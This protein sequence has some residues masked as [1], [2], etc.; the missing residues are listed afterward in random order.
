MYIYSRMDTEDGPDS[1]NNCQCTNMAQ[2]PLSLYPEVTFLLLL[3]VCWGGWF[4]KTVF[5]MLTMYLRCCSEYSTVPVWLLMSWLQSSGSQIFSHHGILCFRLGL[6]DHCPQEPSTALICHCCSSALLSLSLVPAP[7]C[8]PP[9][10]PCSS[11]LLW[12]SV[13]GPCDWQLLVI[14]NGWEA[15]VLALHVVIL[16]WDWKAGGGRPE[17]GVRSIEAWRGGMGME[18]T[19]CGPPFRPW[20]PLVI[21]RLNLRTTDLMKK[22][23][24]WELN[25][26]ERGWTPRAAKI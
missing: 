22:Q 16:P 26:R 8:K 12:S 17:R 5:W 18:N 24:I 11:P 20:W 25:S 23:D 19:I 15:P 9:W 13:P 6:V 21:H 3:L 7:S 4:F 10:P 2:E 14:A 1:W